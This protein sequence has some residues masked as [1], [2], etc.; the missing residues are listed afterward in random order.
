MEPDLEALREKLA[1]IDVKIAEGE[2][3]G[4]HGFEQ[5]IEKTM[6]EQKFAPGTITAIAGHGVPERHFTKE[7]THSEGLAELIER[8][9]IDNIKLYM[10]CERKAQLLKDPFVK[11]QAEKLA[12]NMAQDVALC[13][14]RALIRK[15]LNERLGQPASGESVKN[16]GGL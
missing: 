15:E 1:K 13:K 12:E 2:A 6:K 11:D 5:L 4:A 3:P 8:L 9:V 7:P 16:Y 14:A 10:V